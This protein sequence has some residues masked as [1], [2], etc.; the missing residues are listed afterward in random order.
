LGWLESSCCH[1]QI[2]R[3]KFQRASIEDT[4]YYIT[5]DLT[6]ST[7]ITK[8]MHVYMANH[9]FKLVDL[10]LEIRDLLNKLTLIQKWGVI[11]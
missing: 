11:H 8:Q 4:L 3:F 7:E 1:H 9:N 6:K 10:T 5:C 2:R